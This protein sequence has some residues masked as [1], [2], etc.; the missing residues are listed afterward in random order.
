MNKIEEIKQKIRDLN[1]QITYNHEFN[2][3]LQQQVNKLDTE[4][5][6]IQ[7]PQITE[8]DVR[9]LTQDI[10]ELIEELLEGIKENINDYNPEFYIGQCNEI[11]LSSID[12]HYEAS[13]NEIRNIIE[14]RFQIQSDTN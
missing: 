13:I 12:L 6:K 14:S 5:M 7:K 9:T 1:S 2:T 8:G 4:L 11:R 10:I 3:N